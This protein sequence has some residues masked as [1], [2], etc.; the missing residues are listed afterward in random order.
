MND[1]PNEFVS[2]LPS[3]ESCFKKLKEVSAFEPKLDLLSTAA[4]HCKKEMCKLLI[5]KFNFGI[6]IENII[7]FMLTQL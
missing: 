3:D 4:K 5:E 7:N 6:I 2:S 1:D